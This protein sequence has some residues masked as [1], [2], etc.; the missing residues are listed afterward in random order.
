MKKILFTMA[1]FTV[2][3]F[4]ACGNKTEAGGVND[5]DSIVVDSIEVVDTMAVDSVAVDSVVDAVLAE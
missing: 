1:V 2:M 4:A 3:S 5:T